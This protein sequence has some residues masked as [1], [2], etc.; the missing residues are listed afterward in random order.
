MYFS[1][2]LDKCSDCLGK[3]SDKRTGIPVFR[4]IR[5]AILSP[6]SSEQLGMRV[7]T[8]GIRSCIAN[9]LTY[10]ILFL[11]AKDRIEEKTPECIDFVSTRRRELACGVGTADTN[12]VILGVPAD[13]QT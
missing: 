3:F 8:A 10:V 11:L 13:T 12:D 2:A 9:Q 6:C 4:V 5:R 7:V 1:D